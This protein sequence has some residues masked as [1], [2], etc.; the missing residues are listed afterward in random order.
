MPPSKGPLLHGKDQLRAI[1][2]QLRQPHERGNP[3]ALFE[4]VHLSEK[5]QLP[6][7]TWAVEAVKNTIIAHL[8]GGSVGKVGNSNISIGRYKQNLKPVIR[9]RTYRSI[10]AWSKQPVFYKSMPMSV[11]QKWYSKEIFHNNVNSAKAVELSVEALKG[12]FAECSANTLIDEQYYNPLT[13]LKKK[14]RNLQDPE[15]DKGKPTRETLDQIRDYFSDAT[16]VYDWSTDATDEILSMLDFFG[17]PP[18]DPPPHVRAIIS[19]EPWV[20]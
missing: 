4:T 14:I 9:S 6:L 15:E 11:I 3:F 1:L 18:G 16:G 7:P 20:D 2:E 13:K 17:P 10:M 5:W 12:T 8:T 19:N